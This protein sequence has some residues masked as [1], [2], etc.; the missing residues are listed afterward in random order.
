[1]VILG[2]SGRVEIR[3]IGFRRRA[4]G[5][6]TRTFHTGAFRARTGRHRTAGATQDAIGLTCGT[7]A[8]T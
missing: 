4:V 7:Q 1:M 8:G 5:A 3:E 2:V 6:G